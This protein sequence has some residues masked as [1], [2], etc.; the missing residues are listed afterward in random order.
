MIF[1]TLGTAKWEFKRPLIEIETAIKSGNIKEDVIVQGGST[2]FI[3]C[4]ME[5]VPYFTQHE[6]QQLYTNARLIISQGGTG[7]V[8]KGVKMNKKMIV[9][10]RL[11]KYRE[12]IDDHQLEIT[13]EF[14]KKN[15]IIG[16]YEK[17][18]L[19]SL[20]NKAKD[21]KPSYYISKKD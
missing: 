21:F 4:E 16:W 5:T 2:N 15:Y 14:E 11:K 20:L 6:M 9:V 12:H 10:P 17:S 19:I 18:S 13:K 1:V 7:S 8:I 3:S